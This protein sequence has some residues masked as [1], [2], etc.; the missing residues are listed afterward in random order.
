MADEE[1]YGRLPLAR[2]VDLLGSATPVPG[3]G[4]A[5]AVT[6]AIGASLVA[7]VAALSVDRP[8]YAEHAALHAEA[9]AAARAVADR[10]LALADEDAAAYSGYAEALRLPRE[11]DAEIATRGAALRTAALAATTAPIRTVEACLEAAGLAEALAGRSNRNAA[12]D[13]E[14]AAR[15]LSAAAQSAV[16]NVATNLPA[17]GDEGLGRDLHARAEQDATEVERLAA[18]TREAVRSGAARP[19]LGPAA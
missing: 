3:G 17:I 1:G 5:A 18:R 12:S 4:S 16:A 14:V 8:R 7:M 6:G 13:L 9:G 15:L 19:P 10:L 2:F 11:T